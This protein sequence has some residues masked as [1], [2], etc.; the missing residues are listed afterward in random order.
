MID[1]SNCKI[2]EYKYYGGHSGGKICIKYQDKDY[3]L[4]FSPKKEFKESYSNSCI[5]E[6]I[7]CHIIETLGYNVQK[8]ILGT[9]TKNGQEKMV[10]ACLDFTSDGTVLKQFAEIKN[11]QIDTS[12]NGYGTD[13]DE[14]LDAIDSETIY[15]NIKL[16]EFFWELFII[17]ALI[18]NFDRHNGN[19]GFLINEKE[20]KVELAPIF[21]C[22][23]CLYPTLTDQDMEEYLNNPIE[24]EKRVF[25]FPNSALRI[26]NNKINYFDYINSLEN[27]DCN[28]ALLKVFPRI[29]LNK[30]NEIIDN[31]E[32]ISNVRKRFYKEIIKLRY[33]KILKSSYDKLLDEN[34]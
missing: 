20:K 4:K 14:V 30:I 26:D 9:Y 23:S 15:D 18:G 13:L 33:D 16:K 5:S 11:G 10:V 21:D 8:T 22:A 19:W 34:K 7:S 17:D 32:M 25:V 29:D 27:V 3:M 28:N 31:T 24:M 2:N 1:F 12:K 6:Y